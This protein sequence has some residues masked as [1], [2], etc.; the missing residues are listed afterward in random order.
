MALLPASPGLAGPTT[1]S[2]INRY[3]LPGAIDTPSAEMMPDGVLGASL[4]YSD[5][6]NAVGLSFQVLPRVTAILRYGKFDT[7]GGL[8]YI[9]DRSFDFRLQLMGEDPNGWRPAV[10]LGLQPTFPK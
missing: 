3:G 6:G 7:D 8:G 1:G 5:L 9:R 2:V 10:A 4:S